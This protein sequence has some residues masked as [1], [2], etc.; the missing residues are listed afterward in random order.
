VIS[1]LRIRMMIAVGTLAIAAI[2]AVALT[3][4]QRTRTEFR[5]FQALTKI[6][7][8]ANGDDGSAGRV[9]ATLDTHCCNSESLKAAAAALSPRDVFILADSNNR[10]IAKSGKPLDG[11]SDVRLSP[12]GEEVTIYLTQSAHGKSA[13][14]ATLMIHMEGT[15]ISYQ[16]G[17]SAT[18]YVFPVP[19]GELEQPDTI[20]L[21]SVDRS[22]LM[23]TGLVAA[24]TLLATWALSERVVGPVEE[25][26]KAAR[27]LAMGNLT[28][29]VSIAGSDEIA[30]L[31]K[32]FN[33]MASELENQQKLRRNLVDDVVHELRT[34]L[35]ALRCRLDSISDCISN[36]PRSEIE[37]ANGEIA[38]LATL[39]EDLH[40]VALAEARELRLNITSEPLEPIM[41][42]AIR[43]A[44]LEG[45]SR[46]EVVV[47]AGTV[48]QADP[49]RLRQ[50]LLNFLTNASRHTPPAGTVTL[51]AR[52]LDGEVIVEVRNTGS[53]LSSY[54]VAHVFDRF[55]RADPS[56]ERSTGGTGLGLAIVK[57]IIEAHGGR[58]W[59]SSDDLGVSFGFAMPSGIEKA[60]IL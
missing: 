16:A 26:R 35:T 42:S 55:Y 4:R 58:V 23:V 28:R 24:A 10:I 6:A 5:R 8:P 31:S 46:L 12:T 1:S 48:L 39:V 54:E 37:G 40:E 17:G 22:L 7:T 25:L 18:L 15:P 51:H 43:A 32:S 41:A 52:D 38:H 44:G 29:R 20:F 36:D 60:R 14:Q 2:V 49:V 50:V 47:A 30:E 21:G 11:V 34:P 45:D 19:D 3:A 33:A 13:A 59:A 27:E 9:A 53:Q 56:R 57:N